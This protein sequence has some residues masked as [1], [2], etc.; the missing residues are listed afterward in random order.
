MICRFIY[1]LL[2]EGFTAFAA[3]P[4]LYDDLFGQILGLS[5]QECA[6]IRAFFAGKPIRV[7]HGYPQADIRVPLVAI[8]LQGESQS[9]R[10][11]GEMG[12][13]PQG[14]MN[15]PG[16]IWDSNYQL[17]CYAEN[18]DACQYIYELTRAILLLKHKDMAQAGLLSPSYSGQD[19]APDPRYLPANLFVRVLGMRFQTAYVLPELLDASPLARI[20]TGLAL[21]A[22]TDRAPGAYDAGVTPVTTRLSP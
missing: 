20:A 22:G 2:V 12:Q 8:L 19:I 18:A 11:L 14:G 5:P 15:G 6:G 3:D 16:S 4:S 21:P 1:A 9:Q 13:L 10:F 17:M 7:Q